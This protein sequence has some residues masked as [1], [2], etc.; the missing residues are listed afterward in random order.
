V[1]EQVAGDPGQP[2]AVAEALVERLELGGAREILAR[3]SESG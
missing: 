3:A 1:R 2:V